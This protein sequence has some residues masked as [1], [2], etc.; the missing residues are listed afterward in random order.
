MIVLYLNF[1]VDVQL[2]KPKDLEILSGKQVMVMAMA[3]VL[4]DLMVYVPQIS[5][6]S[7]HLSG[8]KD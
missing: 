3:S 5:V 8:M 4:M 2:G 6:C 1:L 7:A